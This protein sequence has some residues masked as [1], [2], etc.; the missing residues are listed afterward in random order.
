MLQEEKFLVFESDPA[1]EEEDNEED[2][3]GTASRRALVFATG[4][5]L[6]LVCKSNT[7]FIDGT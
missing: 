4:Q 2:E 5:N 7:W 3:G 1:E 6:E